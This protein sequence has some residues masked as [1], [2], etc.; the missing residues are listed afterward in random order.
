MFVF[1]YTSLECQVV[2]SPRACHQNQSNNGQPQGVDPTEEHRGQPQGVDPVTQDRKTLFGQI[3]DG[4]MILNDIGG[5]VEEV[6]DQIPEHYPGIHVDLYVVMPNHIHLLFLISDVVA[7]LR[8]CHQNQSNN[9]QP[10]GVDPTQERLS[11]PEIVHRI[12]SLSTHQYILGVRDKGWL[13]FEKRLWQRSYYEHIIR[14]EKD[15]QEIY[16]YIAANPMSWEKDGEF[17]F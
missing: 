17:S 5:M 10:Q 7:G 9:G 8:A 4:K 11:L 13:R 6:I 2:A 16:D 12:K 3:V 15:Y 14:K 1:V